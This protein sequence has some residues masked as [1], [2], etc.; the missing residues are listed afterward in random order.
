MNLFIE[1][2]FDSQS[3][4]CIEE[5][6]LKA[7]EA[8]QKME[9]DCSNLNVFKIT[10]ANSEKS[11]Y[12]DELGFLFTNDKLIIKLPVINKNQVFKLKIEYNAQP[13]RGFRFI[14]P[15]NHYPNKRKQAWTQGQMIES[16]FWFPTLD[17]PQI[18]F[19]REIAIKV[20]KE[21]TSISNG[22]NYETENG[23]D[24]KIYKW[25]EIH[26]NPAYLTSIVTG[27]FFIA[28]EPYEREIELAYYVPDDQKEK[29]KR[30]F[31]D[32]PKI[33]KFFEKYFD[34]LYPYKKYSQTTVQDFEYG[35]MENTTCT[36]LPD[37]IL[38]DEKLL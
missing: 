20:P 37:E 36:T 27:E 12:L 21:F 11:E 2:N 25:K 38:L 6:Q 4:N 34:V 14:S 33:L 5:L 26:P 8:I 15:N 7:F 13:Q 22:N 16:R 24:F 18:K 30:T 32:T 19:P 23:S 17:E 10:F 35:G 31:K 28:S 9:L 29:V 3:I 1:P